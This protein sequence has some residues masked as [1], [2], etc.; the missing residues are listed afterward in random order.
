[1]MQ[2]K[3]LVSF[4]ERHGVKV[5]ANRLLVARTLHASL[6]PLSL[7]ELEQKIVSIDKSG[8]FRA[9]S[10]FKECHLVHV[11]EDGSGGVKYELCHSHSFHD[12]EDAHAHFH[13]EVCG[14][15]LCLDH[16]PIPAIPLPE[17]YVAHAVNY[18]VK[19][20]C[21]DCMMKGSR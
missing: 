13:C 12:D 5:T 2:E 19:G 7:A 4:I 20:V 1:M 15:T 14:R 6:M 17:G 9:L 11:I 18:L 3:K 10:L 21:P 16:V 8:I